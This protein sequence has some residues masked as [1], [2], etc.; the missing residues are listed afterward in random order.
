[1]RGRFISFEGPEGGGKSTHVAALAEA[2][3]AEGKSVLVTREP[4]GTRLAELIRG[5]VREEL[6]DPPVTRAE[7]LLFL[8]SRAQVVAN[9]IK[10]ALARGEWVLCDRFS[11]STFAYQGYGR[12]I[13]VQLLKELNEF[14]TEGLVPD[15]TILLD[16]P[17]EVSRARLA[18]R[19]RVTAAAADR[20]EAAG[21]AFHKRLREGF[22]ALAKAEPGRF[23]VIDSSGDRDEVRTAHAY[24]LVGG[25]RGMAGE[26]AERVLHLLFGEGDLRVHPDIHRLSP[27]KKTRI[28]SVDAMRERMIEPMEKT[29]F[30][31]GWKAGVVLGADRLRAE[32][33]NA[34]LKTLEEPPPQ[35]IFLLLSERPEQLLPTIVSRCQR[36]DL[37]DAR[38]Q[39]LEEPYRTQV[40]DVL[41]SDALT[42]V[43]ARAAAAAKL[44]AILEELKGKATELVQE[45]LEE[46]H[47]DAGEEPDDDAVKALVSSRY[48]E[49]RADFLSTLL[50][51][52][53]DMMAIRAAMRRASIG[54]DDSGEVPLVNEPRRTV[55]EARARKITLAQAFRNVEAVESL[56]KS[57]D[58]NM[59]EEP[60]LSFLMDCAA[61]G[62]EGTT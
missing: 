54:N 45:D 3:R 27:A 29:T 30:M 17:L 55:L 10:P 56:V 23:A 47:S 49:F 4:G 41:A 60:L 8:A 13:D 39:Q 40:L 12:G 9:V 21:E 48:R 61:F 52:F 24:L 34:F 43:T 38:A 1:M 36:I 51:W 46:E 19:Q 20:I 31:G 58:R 7:V 42:G 50:S 25:V 6:E 26:L 15:L 35:T 22:L 57:L 33:A 18:E 2:L 32:S 5:L 14:A 44:T 11:D 28:I 53:R 59:P 16:V 37:P 62:A